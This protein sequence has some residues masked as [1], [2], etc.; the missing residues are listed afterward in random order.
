MNFEI[1][2]IIE[3]DINREWIAVTDDDGKCLDVYKIN[4]HEKLNILITVGWLEL[5]G[6]RITGGNSM[7]LYDQANN[8]F[9]VDVDKNKRPGVPTVYDKISICKLTNLPLYG[10]CSRTVE[11]A[12]WNFQY[13]S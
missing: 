5:K 11:L 1:K 6:A 7:V 8:Q 4:I 12:G 2:Q 3:L 13:V 10:D 9:W